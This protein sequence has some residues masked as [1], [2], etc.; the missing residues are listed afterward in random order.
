MYLIRL[1]FFNALKFLAGLA[2][3]N[4]TSLLD[5]L[6]FTVEGDYVKATDVLSNWT[7]VFK[8]SM[9]SRLFVGEM[10]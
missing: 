2:V 3:K 1:A 4:S 6:Y 10:K 8:R 5:S 9:L 7:R